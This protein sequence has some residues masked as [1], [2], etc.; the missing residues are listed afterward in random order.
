MLKETFGGK[1]QRVRIPSITNRLKNKFLNNR[2]IKIIKNAGW[3]F[4]YLGGMERV[5]EKRNSL[6]HSENSIEE[7]MNNEKM[8]NDMKKGSFKA[9]GKEIKIKWSRI[10][11]DLVRISQKVALN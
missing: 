1:P 11:L 2:E 8:I 5:I 4:S 7:I 3:H 9:R 6:A 10:R